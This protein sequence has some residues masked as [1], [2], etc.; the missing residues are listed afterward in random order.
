MFPGSHIS[1]MWAGWNG[2]SYSGCCIDDDKVILS[3]FILQRDLIF[4]H[5]HSLTLK[6]ASSHVLG[7]PMKKRQVTKNWGG[8]LAN[9]QQGTISVNCTAPRITLSCQQPC[10]GV[11]KQNFPDSAII[12]NYH[13]VHIPSATRIKPWARDNQLC[14]LPQIPNSQ[15]Q[16]DNTYCFSRFLVNFFFK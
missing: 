16:W 7:F 15:K 14:N 13:P 9:T 6:E 1:C 11:L 4:H 10:E 12:C 3:G 5:R 2:W 8:P